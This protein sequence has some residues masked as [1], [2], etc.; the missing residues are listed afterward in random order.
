MAEPGAK[1]LATTAFYGE[2]DAGVTHEALEMLVLLRIDVLGFLELLLRRASCAASTAFSSIF[3]SVMAFSASTRTVSPSIWAKPPLTASNWVVGALRHAQFAVLDLGE[4]RDVAGE[5]ADLALD[6][7]DDDGV[8]RVGIDLGLGR[9]DFERE[10]HEGSMA[11]SGTDDSLL[12]PAYFLA[13][14]MTSSMPPFM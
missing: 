6:R 5:N 10:R 13:A 11:G 12:G 9:D 7:R 4:Q 2:L 8:D 1:D 3:S 14:A